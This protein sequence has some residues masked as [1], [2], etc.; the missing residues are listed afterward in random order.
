M[1]LLVT[2]SEASWQ[3]CVFF[4]LDL[5][6][7]KFKEPEELSDT[8]TLCYLCLIVDRDSEIVV[9]YIRLFPIINQS[10]QIVFAIVTMEFKSHIDVLGGLSPLHYYDTFIGRKAVY[11][12]IQA[13]GQG[14]QFSNLL[15]M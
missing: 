9:F 1:K 7:V 4:P 12:C 3:G 11:F 10:A 6:A 13:K 2:Y 14:G 15:C 8:V 5:T